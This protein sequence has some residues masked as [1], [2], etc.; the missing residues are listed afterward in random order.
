MKLET[1]LASNGIVIKF[2]ERVG[3]LLG[4]LCLGA[5]LCVGCK[6]VRIEQVDLDFPGWDL[7]EGEAVW[8]SDKNANDMVVGVIF[9]RH[10]DGCLHLQ[11][12]KEG[13][14]LNIV[15]VHSDAW[16]CE[17]PLMKRH[18]EGRVSSVQSRGVTAQLGW[19]QVLLQL[20]DRRL[21]PSWN[22]LIVAEGQWLLE[23]DGTGERIELFLSS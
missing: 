19:L 3:L 2:G 17:M 23:N 12:A 6:T 7:F 16:V 18:Y 11:V 8:R 22:S 15:Q 10:L 14:P 4:M 21:H 9:A 5:L 1:S 13:I 20:G